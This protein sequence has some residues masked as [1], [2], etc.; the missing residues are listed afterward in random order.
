MIPQ[1]QLHHR[2]SAALEVSGVSAEEMANELGVHPNTTRNY[3]GGRSTPN[4]GTIRL[5]A[6]VTGVDEHW[7]LTG[8]AP[9]DTDA[10]TTAPN[11]RYQPGAPADLQFL[12]TAA[13]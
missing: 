8:E 2:L 9:T 7:L 6:M 13:A 11:P 5:W 1:W 10:T 3:A 4:K 12:V